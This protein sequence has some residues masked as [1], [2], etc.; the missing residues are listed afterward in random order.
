MHGDY[1]RIAPAYGN[2]RIGRT[3]ECRKKMFEVG[4]T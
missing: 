1:M 2:D 3:W 4:L